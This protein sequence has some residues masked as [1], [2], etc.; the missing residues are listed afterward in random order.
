MDQDFKDKIDKWWG[1]IP[2][3]E[4]ERIEKAN[5]LRMEKF[6]E[7]WDRLAVEKL[8]SGKEEFGMGHLK[9]SINKWTQ[10][11][12]GIRVFPDKIDLNFIKKDN[13]NKTLGEARVRVDFNVN[14]SSTVD[15]IKQKTAELINLV[16]DITLGENNIEKNN[17]QGWSDNSEKARLKSLAM[18]AYEEAAMWAVKASTI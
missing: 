5:E 14:G 3:I 2:D 11:K 9:K 10:C 13:M 6:H 16:N 7:K 12:P 15:A 17:I 18:T 1:T 4:K 8:V